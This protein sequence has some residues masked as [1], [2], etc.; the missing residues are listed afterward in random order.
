MESLTKGY[1]IAIGVHQS[2]RHFEEYLVASSFNYSKSDCIRNFVEK[3]SLNWAQ[4]RRK[5]GYKCI[6]AERTVKSV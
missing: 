2:N 4:W 6:K 1:V 5:F 3:S